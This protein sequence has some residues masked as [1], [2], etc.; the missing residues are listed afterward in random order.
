MIWLY[1]I[2]GYWGK[3]PPYNGV[4]IYFYNLEEERD[5]NDESY[6]LYIKSVESYINE[7]KQMIELCKKEINEGRIKDEIKT[8]KYDVNGNKK[9]SRSIKIDNELALKHYEEE[10]L[11]Y[12]D[13]YNKLDKGFGYEIYKENF[14]MDVKNN[15]TEEQTLEWLKIFISDVFEDENVTLQEGI[16]ADFAGTNQDSVGEMVAKARFK[17]LK[18]S[19]ILDKIKDDEDE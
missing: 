16:E 9:D 13:F 3:K 15:F 18:D 11:D 10:L 12:Q 19:G 17:E 5:I 8:I 2:A 7:T 14:V 1:R 6:W 4:D